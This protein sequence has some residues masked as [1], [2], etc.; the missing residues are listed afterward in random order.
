MKMRRE[1]A[2]KRRDALE[3]A[4]R[5]GSIV[6]LVKDAADDDIDDQYTINDDQY[7]IIT[8]DQYTITDDQYTIN[9][10]HIKDDQYAIITDDQYTLDDQY[11]IK[12][13]IARSVSCVDLFLAQAA[14][15]DDREQR[16]SFV[17]SASAWKRAAAAAGVARH[18]VPA[19]TRRRRSPGRR[20]CKS[21]ARPL[22]TPH[23]RSNPNI[24]AISVRPP[25][26]VVLA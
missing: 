14:P 12:D 5:S 22:Y 21:G 15:A 20:R 13:T 8:D 7:T 18:T 1:K 11:T 16:L 26:L 4:K 10:D 9:D 6:S 2:I 19:R 24:A 25:L 23:S 3:R 17:E